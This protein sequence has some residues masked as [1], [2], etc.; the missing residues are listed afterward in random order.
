MV[1]QTQ[2]L[3]ISIFI[4]MITGLILNAMIYNFHKHTGLKPFRSWKE[5]LQCLVLCVATTFAI[6]KGY[7][8]FD[9]EEFCYSFFEVTE[10]N[11]VSDKDN[12]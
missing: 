6:W 5:G 3:L 11:C 4:G 9:A 8:S 12:F 1:S 2:A 10:T 7:L